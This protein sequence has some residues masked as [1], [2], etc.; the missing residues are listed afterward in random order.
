MHRAHA[1]RCK[2]EVM[3]L[4]EPCSALDPI[5]TA[6]I[7]ELIDELKQRLHDRHRHPQHA[8]GGA[9]LRLH[10]LHV[11]G[12]ADRVRRRPTQIFTKPQRAGAPRTTSP[13]ASAKTG[14]RTMTEAHHDRTHRQG[15]RRANCRTLAAHDRRNGRSRREEQVAQSG[16]ALISGATAS[17]PQQRHRRRSA[18]STSSQ[19]EI[20]EKAIAHHRAA[21]ADGRATCARS[22]ARMRIAND[23]ERIGDLAKNI[24][25][26]VVAHGRRVPAAE[27][28]RRRRAHE[29]SWCS[30]QLKKVLDAYADAR[31]R[32]RRSRCGSATRRS[33]PCTPR[34]S[35][36]C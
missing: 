26:R 23:L 35:A 5:S 9:R 20:E 4:D 15:L 21:P 24:A 2:P 19:R 22:S 7:E 1:S 17:S 8:A 27:A 16:R 11:S 25:K 31:R 33:T 34:C 30:A 10:R 28:A 14:T 6:K 12:R 18:A 32:R 3:L 13:A 36:S 29:P